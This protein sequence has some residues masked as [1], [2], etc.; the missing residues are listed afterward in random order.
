VPALLL[1]MY[2]GLLWHA[3]PIVLIVSLVY[4]ATRHELMGPILHHA[5]RT[6]VWIT[7]FMLVIAAVLAV[8]AWFV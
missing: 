7:T 5:F 1:A 4:G 3:I 8:V 2:T 6:A